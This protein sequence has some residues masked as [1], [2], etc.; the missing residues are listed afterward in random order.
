MARA[1]ALEGEVLTPEQPATNGH[2]APKAVTDEFDFFASDE[3]VT[4]YFNEPGSAFR[5]WARIKRELDYGEEQELNSILVR[6]YSRDQ[7]E[8]AA[9][10]GNTITHVNSGAYMLA[11]LALYIDDWNLTD[12]SGVTV[13]LPRQLDQRVAVMR[14][15]K[16]TW[17]EK[18]QAEIAR[19][20]GEPTGEPTSETKALPEGESMDPLPGARSA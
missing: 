10:I 4:V 8:S 5:V 3:T 15:L 12:S 6:G 18:L 7:L 13:R 11:R 1:N 17:A 20:R 2:D 14:R 9:A 16:K 19:L